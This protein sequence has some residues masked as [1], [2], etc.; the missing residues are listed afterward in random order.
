MSEKIKLYHLPGFEPGEIITLNK[1]KVICK[2]CGENATF[3]EWVEQ[4]LCQQCGATLGA[5]NQTKD[6]EE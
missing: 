3:S 6:M 1:V 5:A 2:G 4:S